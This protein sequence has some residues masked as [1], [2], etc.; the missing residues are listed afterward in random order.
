MAYIRNRTEE[1]TGFQDSA[2]YRPLT[3]FAT[4]FAMVYGT[5]DTMPTRVREYREAG[6]VVHLM[7][8]I[9]WGN[10]NDYLDGS[11]DGQTHWDE[12]QRDRSDGPSTTAS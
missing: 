4:D 12:G 6:Y 1:L 5:D 7:T 3:D 9:A 8:G 11:F 10:Y 2:P